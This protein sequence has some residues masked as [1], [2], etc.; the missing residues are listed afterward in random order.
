MIGCNHS[1]PNPVRNRARI[2]TQVGLTQACPLT[3]MFSYYILPKLRLLLGLKSLPMY[4]PA[5][6]IK[7][8]IKITLTLSSVFQFSMR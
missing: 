8:K 5:E 3:P 7:A 2:Q 4:N 1:K 6:K